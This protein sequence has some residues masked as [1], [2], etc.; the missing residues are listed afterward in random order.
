MAPNRR[1]PKAERGTVDP[2]H[3]SKRPR[4]LAG[5]IADDG[6]HQRPVFS[7][8]LLDRAYAGEW[9]WHLLNDSDARKLLDFL[10]EIAQLTWSEI[11][12][13]TASGRKRHHDQS[14]ER[15]CSD[16]QRR[17]T[18][19]ERDDMGPTMFRFRVGGPIRFWGYAVDGIFYAV[20][21]DP[22]HRVYPTEPN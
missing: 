18:E 5:V 20:W 6:Q 16:A 2:G 3:E 13:Q 10:A 21:W 19:L 14:I 17:L 11:R 9:G 1:R 7:F 12:A 22:R 4:A 8:A 15:L